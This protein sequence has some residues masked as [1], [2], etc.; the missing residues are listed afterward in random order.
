VNAFKGKSFYGY[1]ILCQVDENWHKDDKNRNWFMAF[2]KQYDAILVGVPAYSYAA[3]KYPDAFA[4][5]FDD[6]T[7]VDHMKTA[8]ARD[9]KGDLLFW[10][11][12]KFPHPIDSESPC[13]ELSAKPIT[14]QSGEDETELE[15]LYLDIEIDAGGKGMIDPLISL[16]LGQWPDLRRS[17]KS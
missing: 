14:E 1:I 15:L 17:R 16:Q 8:H 6:Q 12:I 10:F 11:Y 9:A 4:D 5:E 2:V 7:I 13:L 3:C